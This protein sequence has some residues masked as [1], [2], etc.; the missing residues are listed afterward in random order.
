MNATK[1]IGA[2]I[3]TA[4]FIIIIAGVIYA[5]SLVTPML[6]A[7]FISIVCAQPIFWLQKRGVSQ[8]FA[9][10]IV[11]VGILVTFFG[12]G[13]LIVN[14]LSSFSDQ[15]PFYEENLTRMMAGVTQFFADKGIDISLTQMSKV[16]DP[17]RI[18]GLTAGILG[19]LGGL[20]GNAFTIFFLVL[21]LLLELDSISIKVKA[22]VTGSTD[23][24]KYFNVIG[25]SI[26][27]YLSIK[28]FTSLLTGICIWILLAILGVD[29]GVLW[30]LLAFL[31][32]YIPNI[33]SI[34]AA[35]PAVL[36]AAIQM[37]FGGALSTILVF[38]VVNVLIG[39]VLEPKIMG[40]GM[41]LS[42]FVVFF[43]L[44]FWGFI[45]GTVGMFLSVPLT[46][47][48]KIMLEQ[49]PDTRGIAIALGTQEEAQEIVNQKGNP[50]SSQ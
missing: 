10:V 31:L 22:I 18:M 47:A 50:K 7:L 36:F 4:S 8:G 3:Y 15:A 25:T 13:E 38:G 34:L 20:L 35:I 9:I 16:F 43:A 49:N 42:T 6:L 21:F 44:I 5:N 39:N 33:G 14:S 32:N 11:F 26:R 29:Y 48:I 19:Q 37:G 28:T 46:I 17:S 41:G 27:H 12:F 40:K 24:L 30:G 2:A 45:L 1:K 23:R